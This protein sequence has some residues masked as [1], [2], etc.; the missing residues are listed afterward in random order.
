MRRR[1]MAAGALVAL[2]SLANAD[3][4]ASAPSLDDVMAGGA[5][6]DYRMRVLQAMLATRML[7]TAGP[8]ELVEK[9]LARRRALDA[10][11]AR[12]LDAHVQLLMG[13]NAS[14]L[15]LEVPAIHAEWNRTL[16]V[17]DRAE[18]AGFYRPP[19]DVAEALLVWRAMRDDQAAIDA[20]P[21]IVGPAQVTLDA[22]LSPIA[23]PAGLRYLDAAGC[24]ALAQA[25]TRLRA[26]AR[27]AHEALKNPSAAAPS[28]R[29]PEV[30]SESP[31]LA[32]LRAA[33][34]SWNAS[35][36]VASRGFIALDATLPDRQAALLSQLRLNL[37]PV[38]QLHFGS[39]G[40]WSENAVRW[41]VP[42]HADTAR[43]EMHWAYT[44]GQV[45][46]PVAI[47]MAYMK[48]GA[49]QQVLV[50]S[51]GLRAPDVLTDMRLAVPG[52]FTAEGARP[53]DVAGRVQ[54]ALA[55]LEQSLAFLPGHRYE[56]AKADAPAN[57]VALDTLVVG[58]PSPLER[59]VRREI[60]Q[61]RQRADPWTFLRHHLGLVAS[62]VIGLLALLGASGRRRGRG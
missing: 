11:S 60:E 24:A 29:A 62:I 17:V 36:G 18:R 42:P 59:G 54:A 53:E 27:A 13:V 38:G 16:A 20:A 57:P 26:S 56:D 35:I 37:D 52:G 40:H 14:S 25:R 51:N 39:H 22:N 4:A 6:E 23:L 7:A 47:D 58:G 45:D 28:S 34:G 30:A 10:A 21:W 43:A 12:L 8:L 31:A 9:A 2:A 48:L 1:W 49:T 15:A 41:V 5:R 19:A 61:Q 33:D 46:E 55:P 3:E 50:A 32:C 44:K